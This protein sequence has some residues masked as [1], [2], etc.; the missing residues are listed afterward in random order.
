MKA[1][2]PEGMNSGSLSFLC[3]H[4]YAEGK[5]DIGQRG[6][7]CLVIHGGIGGFYCAYIYSCVYCELVCVVE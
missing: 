1:M 7:I 6:W 3:Q 4:E 5:G 2:C